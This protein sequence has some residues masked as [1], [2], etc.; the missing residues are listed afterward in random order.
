[1]R[2]TT[3]I[4]CSLAASLG[5][6]SAFTIPPNSRSSVSVRENPVSGVVPVHE[7][8]YG[9]VR[10]MLAGEDR[11]E[12]D[13]PASTDKVIAEVYRGPGPRLDNLKV[14]WKFGRKEPKF[15]SKALV[16]DVTDY[17]VGFIVTAFRFLPDGSLLVG[18]MS[19]T[20]GSSYFEIWSFMEPQVQGLGGAPSDV[21]LIAGRVL[22]RVPVFSTPANTGVEFATC[23]MS[24]G[25]I[26]QEK[27][28][29]LTYPSGGLYELNTANR[30]VTPVASAGSTVGVFAPI[31]ALKQPWDR[32]EYLGKHVAYGHTYLLSMEGGVPSTLPGASSVVGLIM[33]DTDE[34][35]SI[36][37]FIP[38]GVGG[39]EAFGLLDQNHWIE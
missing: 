6:V 24:G 22:S 36:D 19:R 4:V 23:F 17:S 35:G 21:S 33:S 16:A 39:Y 27:V 30:S 25:A 28:L 9:A 29:M 8:P 3:K 7:A 38:Y 11:H 26:P 15:W 2:T 5:V 37:D 14:L 1:M 13:V 31:A 18:G 12:Y 10:M 32:A 34:D 20:T